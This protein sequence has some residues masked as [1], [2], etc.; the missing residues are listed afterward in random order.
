MAIDLSKDIVFRWDDHNP[1]F[2]PVLKQGGIDVVLTSG[3]PPAF[4]DACEARGV[5]VAPASEL[6]V[7]DWPQYCDAAPGAVAFGSGLWP[8]ITREPAAAG[9]DEEFAS[10]SRQPWL[11]ANGFRISWLKA[12]CP[13]KHPALAYLPDASSGL[14]PDRVVPYETLELALVEAWLNGG[15]YVLALEQRYRSALLR[16]DAKALDAWRRLGRTAGWLK[17]HAHLFGRPVLPAITLLVDGSDATAELANLM[18][19]QNA[20]PALESAASP[21][22]PDP[23]RRFVVVAASLSGVQA[24]A[25]KR[26]LAHADAGATVVTDRDESGPWW[27]VPELALER[28]EPDRETYRL[29][30]GKVIAYKQTISDPSDFALDVIDLVTQAKRA[31]RTWYAGTIIPTFSCDP[32]L[33]DAPAVLSIINYGGPLEYELLFYVQG[34]YE[35]AVL[36]RPEAER[37]ELKT[38]RRG[39]ATEITVPELRRGGMVLFDSRGQGN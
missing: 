4:R 26:I 36:L 10:P 12:L 25:R 1:A 14:K 28:D 8:G 32:N 29:G 13:A 18:A 16:R 6:T 34:H 22:A 11:D 35:R 39:A 38:A 15:N 33:R 7:A 31:V 3:A 21:P 2:V 20:S 23:G 27:R 5:R 17:R 19:R 24:E 30:R 9:E 37:L